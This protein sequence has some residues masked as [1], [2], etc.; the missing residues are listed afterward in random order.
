MAG[1]EHEWAY[2]STQY[3]RENIGF[4]TRYTRIEVYMCKTCLEKKQDTKSEYVS[5]NDPAPSWWRH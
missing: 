1:H 3:C 5:R 4:Q 2:Q